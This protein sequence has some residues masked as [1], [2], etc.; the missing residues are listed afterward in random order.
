MCRLHCT[1]G[2]NQRSIMLIIFSRNPVAFLLVLG[3]LQRDDAFRL[4][5]HTLPPELEFGVDR[6]VKH[7]VILQPLS[8]ERADWRMMANLF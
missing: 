5:F 2:T 1:C 4:R 6:S 3:K 8:V 7:K